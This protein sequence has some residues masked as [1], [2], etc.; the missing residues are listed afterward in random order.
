MEQVVVGVDVSQ[1]TLE[2]AVVPGGKQFSVSNDPAGV[3]Q[4]K[5]RLL[6]L[7]PSRVVLEATGK[8]ERLAASE[9]GVAGLVVLV[10]NPAQVRHYAQACGQRAKTDKL[11]ARIIAEFARDLNPEFHP[12]PDAQTQ[13]LAALCRRRTQLLEMLG[14]ESNRLARAE[15]VIRTS[16][17]ATIRTLEREL[18]RVEDQI[19]QHI[20]NSPM[21]QAKAKLLA[22]V[23]GIGAVSCSVLLSR[24]PELGQVSRQ[25]I[26]A[27]V[28]VAPFADDSGDY[29]GRRH[30]SGGRADL[31][32]VLYM[33]TLTA[34]RFNPTLRNH[35]QSLRARGLQPKVALI[36]TLRKL[37]GIL[38]A[39]LR[40]NTPWR[41]P[42]EIRA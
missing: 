17:K 23:K 18:K 37:L 6:E 26:C 2:V 35:Y 36:A 7:A 25:K 12:L 15:V 20:R 33:A 24:L 16:L 41:T 3:A 21:W 9:L 40:D 14:A 4:L 31:R 38:N 19:D 22:T 39:M 29:H 42:C 11:D 28:G 30:I 10:V 13:A 5:A 1:A 32:K 27:L 34:V 8:L